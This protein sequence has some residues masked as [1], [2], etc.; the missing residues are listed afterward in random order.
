[1]ELYPI[2][3]EPIYKEM[4]W[5]GNRLAG[6]GRE[7]PFKYTG[8]SWDISCREREMGIVRNGTYKGRTFIE[9]IETD[10]VKILGHKHA[11]G[12]FPLLVKLIDA[13]DFLS[14][15]VHPGDEY[16]RA[17]DGASGK[18]EMWYVLEAPE[19]GYLIIGLKDGVT[20]KIF[21]RALAA[22]RGVEECLNRLY[23][24]RGDV[25]DIPAGL[26]H[27]VGSGIML[28]EIQQ[29]SDLTYRVYDYGRAGIDGKPRE[30]HIKK[31]LDVIDFEQKIPR[32]KAA[33]RK[34]NTGSETVTEYISNQYFHV[35]KY[36][37][38]NTFRERTDAARFRVLT[39]VGGGAEIVSR[40]GTT[41]MRTGD[42][43]FLPAALGEYEIKGPCSLLMSYKP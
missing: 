16:A 13:N 37:I 7:L 39:C 11:A 38:K 6:Y 5:G 20:K 28:A 34:R 12:D 15:Q 43:V 3:F 25:I 22:G 24:K 17:A 23:V 21:E 40:G 41:A 1:M 33:G 2:L 14:V 42:S 4:V 29:N 19:D 35:L 8:E 27:A 30:L 26:V 18:N 36:D 32:E 9:L 10:R 31:A